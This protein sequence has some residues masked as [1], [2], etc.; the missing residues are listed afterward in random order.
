M[1]KIRMQYELYEG[2]HKSKETGSYTMS[3]LVRKIT[4]KEIK[5]FKEWGLHDIPPR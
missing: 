1:Q 5:R 2:L 3:Q 4:R